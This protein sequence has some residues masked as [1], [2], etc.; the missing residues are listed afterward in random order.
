[1]SVEVASCTLAQLFSKRSV[2]SANNIE[3]SGELAIPEYQRPYRWGEAQI[4]KL[5]SDY[6]LFLEKNWIADLR[7]KSKIKVHKRE[8]KRL[9]KF[10]EKK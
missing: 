9:I 10:Y 1:M 8:L 2:T 6:Q 5:L 3:I 7:K 4:E